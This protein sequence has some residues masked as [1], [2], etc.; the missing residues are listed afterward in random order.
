MKNLSVFE[1]QDYREYLQNYIRSRPH[2]G[3]GEKSKMALAIRCHNAYLSQILSG[4][5]ELSSEQAHDLARY[6][7]LNGEE[8]DY[9][10]LLVH[11]F[12]AGTEQLKKYYEQKMQ[13]VEQRRSMLQNRIT[14]EK[15]LSKEDQFTYFGT[16]YYSVIHLMVS[17][18]T[19]FQNAHELEKAL[20]LPANVVRDVLHFLEKCGLIERKEK[21][22]GKGPVDI[23]LEAGSP[24][25]VPHHINWRMQ[26]IRSLDAVKDEDFHYSSVVTIHPE[27][28]VK[29]RKKLMES[30]EQVR[31]TVSDSKNETVVA[32]LNLDWF[33]VYS[34]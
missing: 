15:T 23:Y 32:S 10:L 8:I 17:T 7:G 9:F 33:Q 2:Q 20:N 27:D 13:E 19:G 29:I 1:Y 30:I 12:R 6:L 31:K 4:K 16:W 28:W 14:Y 24:M 5:S 11:Y 3:H 25:L 18:M 21:G 22:F 26:A 34:K